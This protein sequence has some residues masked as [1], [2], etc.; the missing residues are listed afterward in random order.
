MQQTDKDKFIG[1]MVVD[2]AAHEE[3]DHWTMAPRSSVPVGA[4]IIRSIW[5]FKIKRVPSG[6]LNKQKARICSNGGM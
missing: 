3:C 5:S 4:K 6:S 2:V 1:D